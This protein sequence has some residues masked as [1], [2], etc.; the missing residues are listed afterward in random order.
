[1]LMNTEK[2]KMELFFTWK[3]LKGM[4]IF[5]SFKREVLNKE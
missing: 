2:N 1:M 4:E 5:W 3:H